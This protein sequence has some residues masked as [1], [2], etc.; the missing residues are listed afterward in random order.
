LVDWFGQRPFV[1]KEGKKYPDLTGGSGKKIAPLES[2]VKDIA[3]SHGIVIDD[4]EARDIARRARSTIASNKERGQAINSYYRKKANKRAQQASVQ[5]QA[6]APLTPEQRQEMGGYTQQYVEAKREEGAGWRGLTRAVD[7]PMYR[8]QLERAATGDD[9]FFDKETQKLRPG[10]YQALLG[11]FKDGSAAVGPTQFERTGKFFEEDKGLP[12]RII[13]EKRKKRLQ[14]KYRKQEEARLR[15]ETGTTTVTGRVPGVMEEEP[16]APLG[17][18]LIGVGETFAR[19]EQVGT[20]KAPGA[21]STMEALQ[22]GIGL[23]FDGLIDLLPRKGKFVERLM[24]TAERSPRALANILGRVMSL[25]GD[26]RLY[27][28]PI[29]NALYAAAKD[30]AD[31]A[32]LMK[33][34]AEK[35][36]ENFKRAYTEAEKQYQE[37]PKKSLVL[38]TW[39]LM[40]GMTVGAADAA[41]RMVDGLGSDKDTATIA[42]G[43]VD[44]AV[45]FSA[46]MVHSAV[47]TITDPWGMANKRPMEM[48]LNLSPIRAIPKAKLNSTARRLEAEVK[49]SEAKTLSEMGKV[50]EEIRGLEKGVEGLGKK[51]P[52][53]PS[54]VP[55]L[56]SGDSLA[57]RSGVLRQPDIS[58]M[59]EMLGIKKMELDSLNK[60]LEDI[61]KETSQKKRR[62]YQLDALAMGIDATGMLLG[63]VGF[64][65]SGT[66]LSTLSLVD[67]LYTR[68]SKAIG[69][70]ARWWL[71][72]KDKRIPQLMLAMQRESAGMG[73]KKI[74]ELDNFLQQIPK[75]LR[76]YV[77]D[78]LWMEDSADGLFSIDPTK[79]LIELVERPD[80]SVEWQLNAE[81]RKKA[82]ITINNTSTRLHAAAAKVVD[83]MRASDDWSIS[84]YESALREDKALAQRDLDESA[85]SPVDEDTYRFR[86]LAGSR[87]AAVNRYGKPLAGMIRSLTDEAISLGMFADPAS[88]RQIYFP[89][90]YR[91]PTLVYKVTKW[92]TSKAW[93]QRAKKQKQE[94]GQAD[95]P[96]RARMETLDGGEFLINKLRMIGVPIEARMIQ[97]GRKIPDDIIKRAADSWRPVEESVGKSLEGQ[98]TPGSQ[99][100]VKK[101]DGVYQVNAQ[102]YLRQRNGQGLGGFG[103]KKGLIENVHEGVAKLLFDVEMRK[104]QDRMGASS[105]VSDTNKTGFIKVPDDFLTG[106]RETWKSVFDRMDDDALH[107]RAKEMRIDVDKYKT[108]SE[109]IRAMTSKAPRKY[110]SLSKK[111]LQ[112]DVFLE[113]T[114]TMKFAEDAQGKFHQFIRKWKV[115][116]TAYSP[117]TAGRNILTNVLLFAPM[118]GVSPFNP[119]NLPYYF[120]ILDDMRKPPHLRSAEWK[121]A[122][123]DGVFDASEHKVELGVQKKVSEKMQRIKWKKDGKFNPDAAHDLTWEFFE[124]VGDVTHGRSRGWDIPGQLYGVG[125]DLFRGAYY[126]KQ[127]SKAGPFPQ[128]WQ[129]LEMAKR[130]RKFFI[131][132]ESVPG[133]VQVLRAPFAPVMKSGESLDWAR[134]VFAV[135]GQPFI[136]FSARA[137]PLMTSWLDANPIKARMYMALH[138]QLSRISMQ[139]AGLT[140][141]SIRAGIDSLSPWQRGSYASTASLVQ[142]ARRIADSFGKS[143]GETEH[144]MERGLPVG[145]D[146]KAKGLPIHDVGFLSPFGIVTGRTDLLNEDPGDF[147]GL[148]DPRRWGVDGMALLRWARD[149]GFGT[150][151]VLS[152]FIS[153]VTGVDLNSGRAI[154]DFENDSWKTIKAKVQQYLA[155]RMFPPITPSP[156]DLYDLA[157][158]DGGWRER[159]GADESKGD[160][161]FSELDRIHGGRFFEGVRAAHLQMPDYRQR[162]LDMSDVIMRLAG[163]KIEYSTDEQKAIDIAQRIN[164]KYQSQKETIK[165]DMGMPR[166]LKTDSMG[167]ISQ[168][169][170]DDYKERFVKQAIPSIKKLQKLFSKNGRFYGKGFLFDEYKREGSFDFLGAIGFFLEDASGKDM[171][172]IESAYDILNKITHHINKASDEF[173]AGQQQAMLAKHEKRKKEEAMVPLKTVL[174]P[175][176]ATE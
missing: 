136:A 174:P 124:W 171:A 20:V 169:Q 49:K 76:P 166:R 141:S 120:K 172:D 24:E 131:D 74:L 130:A 167:D 40:Q 127:L 57:F 91:D 144:W 173:S 98:T 77:A 135:A 34:D 132:Y 21:I 17:H 164:Q 61:R 70:N 36:Y 104:L 18:S 1:Y 50:A 148:L 60:K 51:R 101:K 30:L 33:R 72:P 26:K 100:F 31:G 107:A 48:A 32:P 155:R 105:L 145:L 161:K 94:A 79:N 62:A 38:E 22:G 54:G 11:E 12:E 58:P 64:G 81:G 13:K 106:A 65:L 118:A 143:L 165:T 56:A 137:L 134:G 112:E 128:P 122:K 121:L 46:P 157:A 82:G 75:R 142:V 35:I 89:N 99:S 8:T 151:P 117:V 2:S 126:Y 9:P 108:R 139:E 78:F 80:G 170:E 160:K 103:M 123:Q 90:L 138:E 111:Y 133:F 175:S 23:T 6:P 71:A 84:D 102:M 29:A 88:L 5:Q 87:L 119:A 52:S 86:I 125:D 163:I 19:P 67:A 154:F 37:N 109:L 115:G 55:G 96:K 152:P 140:D 150:N 129:R 4:K 176:P 44:G 14:A 10:A 159:Y 45:E 63:D 83:D 85:R 95:G 53:G 43:F 3:I 114:N 110:G 15:G 69:A 97:V 162:V 47:K 156:S 147:D 59:K 113:M 42:Q 66:G 168:K 116:Q 93:R 146:S 25:T 41:V 158:G 7:A 28:T 68:G 39:E 149:Q 27:N 16:S 153:A 73:T 92:M